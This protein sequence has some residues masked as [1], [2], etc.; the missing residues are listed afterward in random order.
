MLT[1][2]RIRITLEQEKERI[3][4]YLIQNGIHKLDDGRQLYEATLTELQQEQKHVELVR[5]GYTFNVTRTTEN[6]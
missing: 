3:I 2:N 6:C 5:R 4:G 1:K